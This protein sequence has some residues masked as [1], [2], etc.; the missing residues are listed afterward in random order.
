[1]FWDL[2]A[3]FP[4]HVLIWTSFSCAP[5]IPGYPICILFPAFFTLVSWNDILSSFER[6][7]NL[8]CSSFFRLYFRPL[9]LISCKLGCTKLSSTPQIEQLAAVLS[10]SVLCREYLLA[11][12]RFSYFQISQMPYCFPLLLSIKI[13]VQCKSLSCQWFSPTWILGFVVISCHPILLWMLSIGFGFCYLTRSVFMGEFRKIQ[14]VCY[15]HCHHPRIL[16][17]QFFVWCQPVKSNW[18]WTNHHH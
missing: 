6:S 10:A 14:K 1:M 7:Q 15:C 5:N 4:I 16:F 18:Q 12:L 3:L 9:A 13:L 2:L 11:L 8:D 17:S